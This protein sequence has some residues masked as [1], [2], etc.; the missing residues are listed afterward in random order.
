M[1]RK[2]LVNLEK[3]L[4]IDLG[5][6]TLTLDNNQASFVKYLNWS[7]LEIQLMLVKFQSSDEKLPS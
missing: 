3:R 1:F 5:V 4:L 6:I 7:K 2:E